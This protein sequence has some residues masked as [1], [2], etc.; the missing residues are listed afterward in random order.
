MRRQQ[1][2]EVLLPGGNDI[3]IGA[4]DGAEQSNAVGGVGELGDAAVAERL[5]LDS[6][7]IERRGLKLAFG[8]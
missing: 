7:L 6:V 2:K 3:A 4:R 5:R 8:H 1:C